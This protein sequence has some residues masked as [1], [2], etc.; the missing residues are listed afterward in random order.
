MAYTYK[1]KITITGQSGAGTDYQVPFLV[2]ESTGSTGSNFNLE[3]NSL[4]FPSAKNNGGD[5]KFLD[6]TETIDLPFWVESVSGTTPNRIA[7]I[8][9]KV[10]AD[11]GSN[12]DIYVYYGD[13]GASNLSNGDDTFIL[14]DD[15]EGTGAVDSSKWNT[16]Y[17]VTKLNDSTVRVGGTSGQYSK[18]LSKTSFGE[19]T[20][21]LTR[22][23]VS[24]TSVGTSFSARYTNEINDQVGY[25]C[26]WDNPRVRFYYNG[27]SYNG[28]AN[29][30]Y[31]SWYIFETKRK[32]GSNVELKI[33]G[34]SISTSSNGS[35]ANLMVSTIAYQ[36]DYNYV[37]YVCVKKCVNT[38]PAFNSAG[39]EQS[40]ISKSNFMTFF[41]QY[42]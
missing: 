38:E 11:L 30:Y 29:A 15:F 23:Y 3:G 7:K 9:V 13:S 39:S 24:M 27:N 26:H 32:G 5:L 40:A 12:R 36:S 19:N 10:S 25:S 33:D 14:F 17:S 35:S 34:A 28:L 37:D 8:W 16:V 21:I 22:A 6:S 1:K 2:G 18:L 41:N 31:S 20:A 42:L 4:N